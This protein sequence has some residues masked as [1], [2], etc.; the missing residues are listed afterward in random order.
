MLYGKYIFGDFCT[1]T[2]WTLDKN[3]DFEMQELIKTDIKISS[4][5]EYGYFKTLTARSSVSGLL[6]CLLSYQTNFLTISGGFNYS[7]VT[8]NKSSLAHNSDM[9][10]F[11][12]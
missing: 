2:I 8:E 11:N 3:N 1:G 4:F 6:F 9:T 5:G 7:T 12:V 10:L